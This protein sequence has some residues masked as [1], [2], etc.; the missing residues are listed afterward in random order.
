[1]YP[2]ATAP[3]V[4][5]FAFKMA[6]LASVPFTAFASIMVVPCASFATMPPFFSFCQ[7]GQSDT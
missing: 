7:G 6:H 4:Y 2:S 5:I 1:M 3:N